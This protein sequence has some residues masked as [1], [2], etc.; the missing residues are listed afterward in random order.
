VQDAAIDWFVLREDRY[1]RLAPDADGV[2]R[3]VVFPGLWLDTAALLS[4]DLARVHAV[5]R[6]GLA[7]PAH[8]AFVTNLTVA[9]AAH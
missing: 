4:G 9:Q 7:D 5:L 3:S 2:T 1:D 6:D 8:A